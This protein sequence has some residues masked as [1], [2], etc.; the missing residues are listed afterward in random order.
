MLLCVANP[1]KK[2]KTNKLQT[3]VAILTTIH[4]KI[5]NIYTSSRCMKRHRKTFDQKCPSL[6]RKTYIY[7]YVCRP[8]TSL[9]LW[10]EISAKCGIGLVGTLLSN[11]SA[12]KFRQ[13]I[14]KRWGTAPRLFWVRCPNFC[15]EQFNKGNVRLANTYP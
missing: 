15:T 1:T 14:Q 4:D 11:S 3:S 5:L 8:T 7:I 9:T 10:R 6:V 2:K 13:H 12:Q